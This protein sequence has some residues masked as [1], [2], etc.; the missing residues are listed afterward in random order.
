MFK[1]RRGEFENGIY[2]NPVDGIYQRIWPGTGRDL[3]TLLD[4][5]MSG[6]SIDPEAPLD[7][8]ITD[9]GIEREGLRGRWL[10]I[11]ASMTTATS[12]ATQTYGEESTEDGSEN[13][14]LA[15]VYLTRIR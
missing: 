10:V 2:Q 12:T 5:T 11:N 3:F 9:V 8:F 6:R 13:D 14:S 7:A 15:G 1:A 4:T